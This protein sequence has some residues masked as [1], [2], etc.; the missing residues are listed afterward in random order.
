MPLKA[1]GLPGGG[2][3]GRGRDFG[4]V[5]RL[6]P[7]SHVIGAGGAG[8]AVP[9]G[10][11]WPLSGHSGLCWAALGAGRWVWAYCALP[12]MVT[13]AFDA[14]G[15]GALRAAGVRCDELIADLQC[16]TTSEWFGLEVTF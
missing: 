16:R 12:G 2:L 8:G 5:P 3:G 13:P 1:D 10:P 15:S 6:L 4:V 14:F 11:L 7:P 9:D